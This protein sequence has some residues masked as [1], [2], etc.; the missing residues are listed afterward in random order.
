MAE[1]LRMMKDHGR[2]LITAEFLE[3]DDPDPV[4]EPCDES[5]TVQLEH[6]VVELTELTGFL[7]E[8]QNKFEPG[9]TKIDGELAIRLHELLPLPRSLAG[10]RRLWTWLGACRYPGF[11]AHRWRNKGK[12]AMERYSGPSVR[13]AFARLWWMV[14]TTKQSKDGVPDYSIARQLLDVPAF[15]DFQEALFGRKCSRYDLVLSAAV[16]CLSDSNLP[17]KDDL[18]ISYQDLRR[19]V[20][21]EFVCLLSTLVLE[22]MSE[23]ELRKELTRIT[24]VVAGRC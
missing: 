6:C 3:A 23:D 20:L 21:K 24:K 8:L 22:T 5:V 9:D 19:E 13:Q 2:S 4:A 11:V 18:A 7:A 15:Q 12:T 10:D 14:E 16:E 17:S 1:Y